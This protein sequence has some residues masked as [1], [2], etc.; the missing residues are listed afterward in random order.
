[1]SRRL[2][3][4]VVCLAISLTGCRSAADAPTPAPP[5]RIELGSGSFDAIAQRAATAMADSGILSARAL[6]VEALDRRYLVRLPPSARGGS[7]AQADFQAILERALV[8][9]GR[10]LLVDDVGAPEVRA[11]VSGRLGA[12]EAR[13][14]VLSAEGAEW[15]DLRA[16]LRPPH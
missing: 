15:L 3:A 10:F 8:G 13:I 6:R 1:V 2:A 7:G 9:T 11:Q 16:L 5:A 12:E 14:L 4:A